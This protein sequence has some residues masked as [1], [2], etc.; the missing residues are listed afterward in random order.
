MAIS[1]DR[2]IVGLINSVYT[3]DSNGKVS[4]TVNMEDDVIYKK[5]FPYAYIPDTQQKVTSYITM[6][7]STKTDRDKDKVY[8]T[9]SVELFVITHQGHMRLLKPP[10]G[11][12]ATRCDYI[13]E[14]LD[15]KFNGSTDFGI[16]EMLVVSSDEGVFTGTD[17]K[18]RKLV[19]EAVY[20]NDSLCKPKSSPF[21]R[22]QGE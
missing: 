6:A 21:R 7:V 14:L 11:R 10:I 4:E 1:D 13:A 22:V 5:L 16:G 17:W 20:F 12:S 9:T 3:I 18:Y 8:V 15:K 2:E 19:Y